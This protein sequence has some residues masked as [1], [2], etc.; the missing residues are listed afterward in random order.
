MTILAE[1]TLVAQEADLLGRLKAILDG[2][3]AG[4]AFRLL[5]APAD[6]PVADDEVLV[7]EIDTDRG[8]VELHPRKLSDVNLDDVLH[9]AQVIDPA[10]QA[11][12]LHAGSPRA[13]WCK[14]EVIDGRTTHLYML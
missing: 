2:H 6:L 3:P 7:Q 8:V 13:E 11:L 5:L 14:D 1:D 4:A 9:A 12:A 10:D